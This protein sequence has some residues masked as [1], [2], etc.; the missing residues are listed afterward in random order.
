MK[1]YSWLAYYQVGSL[2]FD[3]SDNR[4]EQFSLH[5]AAENKEIAQRKAMQAIKA[6]H[7]GKNCMLSLLER[8][9]ELEG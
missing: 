7:E 6:K 3:T 8:K 1:T 2:P 9:E 4:W 5:V